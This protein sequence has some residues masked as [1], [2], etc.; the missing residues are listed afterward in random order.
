[1]LAILKGTNETS[2]GRTSERIGPIAASLITGVLYNTPQSG[3]SAP[4]PLHGGWFLVAGQ[5]FANRRETAKLEYSKAL[6]R[7]P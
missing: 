6:A 4:A 5:L 1:L 7:P 2:A 3:A